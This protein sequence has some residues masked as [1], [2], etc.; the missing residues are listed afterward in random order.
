MALRLGIAFQATVFANANAASQL[1][2]KKFDGELVRFAS[3]PEL[4]ESTFHRFTCH[5][6]VCATGIAVRCI[7]PHLAHKSSDPAVIVLDQQGQYV[8]SLLSGHL[9]RANEHARRMAAILDARPVITT[10]TDVEDLPAID[11]LAQQNNLRIGNIKAVKSVSAALLHGDPVYLHDPDDCLGLRNSPWKHLFQFSD[12]TPQ[13]KALAQANAALPAQLDEGP[14]CI[15][16]TPHAPP[17]SLMG[18]RCLYLHPRVVC[19]G[20]GCKRG[21]SAK[22]IL[23]LLDKALVAASLHRSA[24]LRLASIDIKTDEPGLVQAAKLLDAPLLFFNRRELEAFPG[25]SFSP[26]AQ[27]MFDVRGVCEPAALAAAAWQQG[28]A[29]LVL[30]KMAENG[31]TVALAVKEK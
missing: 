12:I 8:I 7:A 11:S 4:I 24:L 16:V 13:K 9:G 19:A 15:V 25:P 2:A 23:A 21:A 26:K 20:I 6:F 3:L 14:A 27:E 31:V 17:P 5:T 10:A 28:K 30:P 29:R 22:N 18:E 1:T